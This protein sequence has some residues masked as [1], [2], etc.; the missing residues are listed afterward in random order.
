M[1]KGYFIGDLFTYN[2]LTHYPPCNLPFENGTI[3]DY[4]FN[5]IE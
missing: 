4:H 3:V 2:L 5:I 1:L